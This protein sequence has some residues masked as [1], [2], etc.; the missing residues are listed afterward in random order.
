MTVKQ[1]RRDVA[2]TD[3]LTPEQITKAWKMYE[4]GPAHTF[5]KRCAEEIIEPNLPEINEKLGQENNALYLAYAVQYVFN[6][7]RGNW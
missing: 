1:P 3:F 5:V 2:I 6:S 4:N 7:A